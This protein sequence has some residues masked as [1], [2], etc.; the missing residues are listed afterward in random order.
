M[1]LLIGK[2]VEADAK[3]VLRLLDDAG[4]PGCETVVVHRY[5]N[6]R[7]DRVRHSRQHVHTVVQLVLQELD[8]LDMPAKLRPCPGRSARTAA[9]DQHRTDVLLQL[10]DSLTDR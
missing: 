8:L 2:D 4:K 5:P 7:G 9:H 1:L 3:L 6:G 10:L